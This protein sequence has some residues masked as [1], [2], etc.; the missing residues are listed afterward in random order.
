MI[1]VLM[2]VAGSGKTTIGRR[3]ART[4]GCSFYD[5]DDFHPPVNKEKMGKGIPLTDE[6]RMP[7]LQALHA[8]MKVWAGKGPDTVLACSA[9]KQKYRDLLSQG[10]LVQWVYLKADREV[11]KE[12]LKR[13]KGHFAGLD[14]LESQL[15]TLQEPSDAWVMDTRQEARKI[16]NCLVESL[17][18]KKSP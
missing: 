7:W 13:R 12:R 14:L 1:V 10:I 9:L 3:L 4:L 17:K 6:D 2:G 8:E 15:E 16:I 5:A 18:G 11:L